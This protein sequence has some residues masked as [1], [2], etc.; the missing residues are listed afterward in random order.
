MQKEILPVNPIDAI[1]T[2]PGSKSFSHRALIAAGLAVG[3]STLQNLLRAEDTS[4]Y[5]PGA[6]AIGLPY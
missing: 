2:L 3:H 5:G 4:V 1:I 6:R